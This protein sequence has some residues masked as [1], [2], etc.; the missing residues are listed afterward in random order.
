MPAERIAFTIGPAH[1]IDP[2]VIFIVNSALQPLQPLQEMVA[3]EFTKGYFDVLMAQYF[4]PYYTS[5]GL[6]PRASSLSPR[7]HLLRDA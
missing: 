4:K 6:V 2:M 7:S 3:R 5:G 1:L